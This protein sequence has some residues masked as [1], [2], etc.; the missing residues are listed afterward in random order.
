MLSSTVGLLSADRGL[1]T[2]H[3]L[4]KL[5]EQSGSTCNLRGCYLIR[6][7]P[8]SENEDFSLLGQCHSSGSAVMPRDLWIHGEHI[9]TLTL[10]MP[11]VTQLKSS[12]PQQLKAELDPALHQP[13]ICTD[14]PQPEL[15]GAVT[16]CTACLLNHTY[17]LLK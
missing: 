10:P 8:A 5:L 9:Q 3:N 1:L 4:Q 12:D 7:P 6:D 15:L 11:Y 16:Q 2:E 13:T 17:S 14:L